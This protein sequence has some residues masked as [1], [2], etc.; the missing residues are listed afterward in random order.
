MK[1]AHLLGLQ[2]PWRCQVCRDLDCLH[3][4]SYGPI[5]VFFSASYNWRSAAL[6]GLSFSTAPPVQALKGLPCLGS[7]SVVWCVRH[8][9]GSPWV[10]SYSVVQCLRH[11]MGQSLYYATADAGVWGEALVMAPP[12]CVTQQYSLASKAARLSSTAIS[13]HN[14]LSQLPSIRLSAVNSSPHPGIAPKSLNSSSQM[15]C[16]GDYHSC[17]EYVWLLQGLSYSHSI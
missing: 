1:V 15:L 16:L 7:F 17:S 10:G 2:G 6:F 11:L 4:R 13:H 14:L 12:P 8:T 5:R 9:E 3:C